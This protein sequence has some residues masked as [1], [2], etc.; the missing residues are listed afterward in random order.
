MAD[1]SSPL[2][3]QAKVAKGA[4]NAKA[5]RG[6][7]DEPEGGPAGATRPRHPDFV[8]GLFEAAIA[9]FQR[10][11]VLTDRADDLLRDTL[12][13]IGLDLERQANVCA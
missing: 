10:A 2:L 5:T 8:S 7:L 1:G 4:K 13:Q 6:R 12:R 3:E 9:E 11:R